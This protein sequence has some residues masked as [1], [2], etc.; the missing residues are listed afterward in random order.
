MIYRPNGQLASNAFA[1]YLDAATHFCMGLFIECS[2]TYHHITYS[3]SPSQPRSL[4]L[5][6][7]QQTVIMDKDMTQLIHLHGMAGP[8][9][10]Q[11]T[12]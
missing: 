2:F 10:D 11:A 5:L 9:A 3:L 7:T 8:S 6:L 12:W 1:P 4:S